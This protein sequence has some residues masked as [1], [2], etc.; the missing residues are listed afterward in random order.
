MGTLTIN[1]I[2]GNMNIAIGGVDVISL[3]YTAPTGIEWLNAAGYNPS[4]LA[5]GDTFKI[6]FLYNT[7]NYYPNLPN[8]ETTYRS[9]LG[10]VDFTFEVEYLSRAVDDEELLITLSGTVGATATGGNIDLTA[11]GMVYTITKSLVGCTMVVDED[12]L[13]QYYGESTTILYAPLPVFIVTANMGYNLPDTITVTGATFTWN[14][15]S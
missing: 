8:I 5:I 13:D 10:V 15:N 9:L 11:A 3:T 12:F 14:P 7:K 4:T 6:A 1:S 2:T